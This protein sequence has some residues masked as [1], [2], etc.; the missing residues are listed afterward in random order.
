MR[1][2]NLLLAAALVIGAAGTGQSQEAPIAPPAPPSSASAPPAPS[3]STM[4]PAKA[5]DPHRD[6]QLY[7]VPLPAMA[8]WNAT[9]VYENDVGIWTVKS[10]DIFPEYG[11]PEIVGLD[12]KGRCTIL[13]SYSGKWARTDTI[14]EGKWLG[15]LAWGDLDPRRDGSELYTG[16]QLGNLYQIVAHAPGIYS[17]NVIARL[18]GLEIH[19]LV[20][21]DLD[22]ARP[23]N[24]MLMFTR[25]GG[26]YL[27]T[28]Q[29]EPGVGFDVTEIDGVSGRVRDA[30]V[31]PA[32]AGEAPQIATVSRTGHAQLLKLTTDGPRWS[33]LN[34][35]DMGFGRIAMRP[36]RPGAP[37]VL[38][39]VCDDGIV[40]RD[41]R[42]PDGRWT[43]DLVYAGPQGN[44]G[45][46]AGRFDADPSRETIAVAGYG[47]EVHL[48]TRQ[49]AGWRVES[50]FEDRDKGHWLASAELDGRNGTDEI[51]LSG[52]GSRVVLLSRPPGYG[53]PGVAVAPADAAR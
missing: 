47:C 3:P 22:P 53:L 36:A 15:G 27:V 40:L 43:T 20:L 39:P 6:P 30:V 44:R 17:V 46:V 25:P 2:N 4:P 1:T 32:A 24:E 41:E 14:G 18:G 8:G 33:L 37:L 16:G 50:V 5:A 10:Y 38:Y 45:V 49:D 21:G 29:Q 13:S 26:L 23:G 48:L 34:R 35:R 7:E 11:C 19:T 42:G 31:L 52:Y 28:P 12:D 51:I 9:L